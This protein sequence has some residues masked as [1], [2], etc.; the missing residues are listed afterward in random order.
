MKYSGD[1]A[2]QSECGTDLK[3]VHMRRYMSKMKIKTEVV[4]KTKEMLI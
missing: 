1:Y 3:W 2:K 4:G